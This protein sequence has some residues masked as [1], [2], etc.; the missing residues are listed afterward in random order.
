MT[1]DR[2]SDERL[3]EFGTFKGA[4]DVLLSEV[5]NMSKELQQL[6]E[7]ISLNIIK[8]GLLE[9]QDRLL[10]ENGKRLMKEL[11]YQVKCSNEPDLHSYTNAIIKHKELTD[12]L[13]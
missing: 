11:E 10:K 8:F 6:R 5:V 1:T 12:L 2:L 7:D 4:K 3:E 13:E 9:T